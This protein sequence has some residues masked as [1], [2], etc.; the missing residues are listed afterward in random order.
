MT[1]HRSLRHLPALLLLSA[2]TLSADTT[3]DTGTVSVTPDDSLT[4]LYFLYAQGD[5]SRYDPLTGN[6]PAGVTTTFALS[7]QIPFPVAGVPYFSLIGIYG[8]NTGV[9]VALDAT[10]ASNFV[11][12]GTPFDPAFTSFSGFFSPGAESTLMAALQDPDGIVADGFSGGEI[13][14]S[15]ADIPEQQTPQLFTQINFTGVTDASLVKFSDATS[16]GTVE[17]SLEPVAT[18]EPATVWL[19]GVLLLLTCALAWRIRR[20][21][22]PMGV[23]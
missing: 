12:A 9:Y 4:N 6:A 21:Q 15:F 1:N 19:L 10:D 22:S 18:P 14:E 13:I 2:L 16:G 3:T 17:V 20:A 8:P 11:A 7:L 5:I 23:R